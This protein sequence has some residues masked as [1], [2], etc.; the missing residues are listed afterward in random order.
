MSLWGFAEFEHVEAELRRLGYEPVESEG[1]RSPR[2]TTETDQAANF[3]NATKTKSPAASTSSDSAPPKELMFD[4]TGMSCA[5]CA[6]K[7]EK[8]WEKQ[9]KQAHSSIQSLTYL[10]NEFILLLV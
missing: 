6:A 9:V 3:S 10:F 7:I 5:N 1:A 8:T 4:V 2:V